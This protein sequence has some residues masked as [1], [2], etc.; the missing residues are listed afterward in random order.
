V[1]RDPAVAA[2]D[3][4]AKPKLRVLSDG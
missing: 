3:P 4:G 2:G 1:K